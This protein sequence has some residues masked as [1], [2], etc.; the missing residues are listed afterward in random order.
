MIRRRSPNLRG[1]RPCS[2]T[3]IPL[4]TDLVMVSLWWDIE[5]LSE[6]AQCSRTGTAIERRAVGP[7]HHRAVASA[8]P[9]RGDLLG[10]PVRRAE[11]IRPSDRVVVVGA[12]CAEI[13]DFGQRKLRCFPADLMVG[14]LQKAGMDLPAAT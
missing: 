11:R 10:P 1:Q 6:N 3:T 5:V 4:V 2:R 14:L 13:V 7:V 9:V 12:G 8:A